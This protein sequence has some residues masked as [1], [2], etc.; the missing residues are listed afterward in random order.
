M[1][2]PPPSPPFAPPPDPTIASPPKASWTNQYIS[3]HDAQTLFLESLVILFLSILATL[4]VLLAIL[5]RHVRLLFW[6]PFLLLL[7]ASSSY[8]P[9]P[10]HYFPD[11]ASFL[12]HL[13]FFS[14][15]LPARPIGS[16]TGVTRGT[17]QNDVDGTAKSASFLTSSSWSCL[18]LS[19]GCLSIGWLAPFSRSSCMAGARLEWKP[20]RR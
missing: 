13:L 9:R 18:G 10:R 12:F 8:L 14:Y 20:G 6:R 17:R 5:H 11:R 4:S 7:K 1:A 19:Y 15:D 16:T 2:A 3:P